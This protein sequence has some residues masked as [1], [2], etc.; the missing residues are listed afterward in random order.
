[1]LTTLLEP[2]GGSATVCGFDIVEQPQEV[3]ARIGYIGQKNGAGST[4]ASGTSC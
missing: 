2:T 1:M 4:S 3:R